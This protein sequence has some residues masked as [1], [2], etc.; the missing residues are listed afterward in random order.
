MFAGDDF[1]FTVH[2]L[3]FA[4]DRLRSGRGTTRAEDAQGT[5]TQSHVSP[6]IL[7]FADHYEGLGC[8]SLG[9]GL[10]FG[11]EGSDMMGWAVK[12]EGGGEGLLHLPC[13]LLGL[14]GVGCRAGVIK[15]VRSIICDIWYHT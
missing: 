11:A 9:W 6:S 12:K 7:V 15:D 10:G 3:L 5:P 4:D 13:T 2:R 14:F 8:S 1:L